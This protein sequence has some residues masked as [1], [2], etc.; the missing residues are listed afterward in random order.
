MVGVNGS[1]KG[2]SRRDGPMRLPSEESGPTRD[3]WMTDADRAKY[4]LPDGP[5][6]IQDDSP[7]KETPDMTT[8]RSKRL[9]DAEKAALQADLL[10]GHYTNAQLSLKYSILPSAISYHA[11][12]LKAASEPLEP[13]AVVADIV[14][15]VRELPAEAVETALAPER[16]PAASGNFLAALDESITQ[17]GR[18]WED[19]RL[20]VDLARFH[21]DCAGERYK[22]AQVLRVWAF[23]K[24]QQVDQHV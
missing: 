18:E 19:A 5:V 15:A 7:R 23:E 16:E 13:V 20:Q 1:G 9:S 24:A 3:E 6:R 17:L 2:N 8:D 21:A 4:G 14:E 10:S 12:R 11:S 22:A